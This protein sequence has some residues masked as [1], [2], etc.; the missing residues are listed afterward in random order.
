MQELVFQFHVTTSTLLETQKDVYVSIC[1]KC[2]VKPV[3]I[4]LPKGKYIHQP[5]F[6]VLIQAPNFSKAY[7]EIEEILKEFS[8][9]PPIRIKAEVDAKNAYFFPDMATAQWNPYFEWHCKIQFLNPIVTES[10]AGRHQAHLSENCLEEGKK[11]LT[12]RY[13]GSKEQFLE[14]TAQLSKALQENNIPIIKE[15]FEFCIYDSKLELDNGW[16]E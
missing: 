14:K 4:L 16:A 3:F 6:T 1:Q 13:Y 5:M 7:H 15:K 9:F 10:L 12:I 8:R 2:N 11:F